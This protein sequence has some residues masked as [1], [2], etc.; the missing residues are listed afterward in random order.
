MT[1]LFLTIGLAHANDKSHLKTEK[2]AGLTKRYFKNK[3]IKFVE[4]GVEFYIF[5]NGEFDF[6]TRNIEHS[7]R[8]RAINVSF[9]TPGG[10]IHYS[11]SR[12]PYRRRARISYDYL[13]R[14][15]SIGNTFIAYDR[16]GRIKKAGRVYIDYNRR[17]LVSH[18]GGL[19]IRYNRWGKVITI[20]GHV[21]RYNR[22]DYND[23][24]YNKKRKHKGYKKHY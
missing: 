8:R 20:D 15:R 21:K 10:N 3:P 23:R 1:S 13:G 9:N 2:V 7:D 5:P 14:I 24:F 22:Y 17:G 11:T 18:V 6:N 19:T 12:N 16:L 4:R